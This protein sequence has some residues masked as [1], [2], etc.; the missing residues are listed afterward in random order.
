MTS[1]LAMD[2]PIR[3]VSDDVAVSTPTADLAA[4]ERVAMFELL[5]TYFDGVNEVNFERDLAEK[6]WVLRILRD[7]RLVGF[8]TLQVYAA[9]RGGQRINIIYSGDTIV[10]PEAWGAPVL[11]RGW[12]SLVRALR[13]E[14]GAEPWY[15]LLLSSG[16]RTYRFLPVFWR[17]FWPR[18]DAKPTA[19]RAALLASLA[20]ERFGRFFDPSTG[21][22]RFPH[23]QRL[24]GQLAAIPEGRALCPDVQFFLQRNPGHVDGDELV[25]LTELSDANLTS[26]GRRMIRGA[27]P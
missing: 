11:A 21:V 24:R 13:E 15:W 19:D 27:S 7:G 16:F 25:C 5:A 22:V 9:Q 2:A 4:V 6:N 17:E 8:T 23:P 18:R 26:A 1:N 3:R 14:R 10:A 20:R 12:I